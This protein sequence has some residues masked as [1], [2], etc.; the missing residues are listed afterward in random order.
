MTA[1]ILLDRLERVRRTGRGRWV[2]RCPAHD[3]RGPSLSIRELDD[4]RVL[5]H[6]FAGC[7]VDAVL[8]AVSLDMEA[9]FPEQRVA[10]RVIRERRPYRVREVVAALRFELVV[11]WTL[12]S[13]VH[14]GRPLDQADR[15]RA[16][17]AVD[18]VLHFLGEL[19]HAH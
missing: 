19:D 3:D 10:D 13:A 11:A 14:Q 1:E 16:G 6:C 15:E 7:G 4:G 18:R 5:A 8:G 9:L 17:V 12:L 2:A